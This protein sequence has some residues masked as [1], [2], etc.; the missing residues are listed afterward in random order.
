MTLADLRRLT[1]RQQ[2][3]VKFRLRNGMECVITEQGI[4]KIP[5]LNAVPDFNLDDELASAG[6]FVI[7][8]VVPPNSKIS[9]K[10]R[11]IKREEM[12]EMSKTSP[13]V[14]AP[15]HEDD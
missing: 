10:P 13:V 3:T 15:S 8:Q 12:A 5:A 11:T 14:A 2:L 4:A 6:E 1:V 7:E 9:V